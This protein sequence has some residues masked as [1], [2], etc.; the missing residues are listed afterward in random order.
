MAA[1][2]VKAALVEMETL[3]LESVE[4]V[5]M[6]RILIRHGIQQQA[7]E[8]ADTLRAVAADHQAI[9]QLKGQLD[10]VAEALVRIAPRQLMRQPTQVRDQVE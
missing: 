4:L 6:E 9:P 3:R 8:S 10:R 1:V 7:Q 5:A 2:A